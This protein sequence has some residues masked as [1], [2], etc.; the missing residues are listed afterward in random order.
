LAPNRKEF[1]PG[2]RIGR[3]RI[4]WFGDKNENE[5]QLSTIRHRRLG[6]R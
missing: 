4:F 2:G 3:L 5:I 6:Q 1:V